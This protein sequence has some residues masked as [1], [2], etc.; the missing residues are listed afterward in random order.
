VRKTVLVPGRRLICATC[1]STHTQPSLPIHDAIF[2]LTTRTGQGCSGVVAGV[3]GVVAGSLTVLL[4]GWLAG[5]LTG[6]RTDEVG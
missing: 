1:P 5:Q 4:V 6:G 2:W 3:G